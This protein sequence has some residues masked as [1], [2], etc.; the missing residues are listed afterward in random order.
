[1]SY[2]CFMWLWWLD[3][4]GWPPVMSRVPGLSWD[5]HC[6]IELIKR[7]SHFS[8]CRIQLRAHL[9]TILGGRS[10]D[11]SSSFSSVSSVASSVLSCSTSGASSS[12][13]SGSLPREFAESS[14]AVGVCSATLAASAS[15]CS[16]R[17]ISSTGD[18]TAEQTV[19]GQEN[20]F[21]LGSRT[22]FFRKISIK[23]CTKYVAYYLTMTCCSR[24]A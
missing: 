8:T 19:V 18:R 24:N 21:S 5:R 6:V 16:G 1:M 7:V 2:V 9:F 11:F 4:I 13:A 23:S 14:A 17:S 10:S 12:V 22:S 3:E 15:R 20:N